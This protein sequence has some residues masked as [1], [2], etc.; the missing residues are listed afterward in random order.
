MG[1]GSC[2][3]C[4]FENVVFNYAHAAIKTHNVA[5][6]GSTLILRWVA[7][8]SCPDL[9]AELCMSISS[10]KSRFVKNLASRFRSRCS[11]SF[12]TFCYVG[13]LLP[14]TKLNPYS[15]RFFVFAVVIVNC[16]FGTRQRHHGYGFSEWRG[17][18]VQLCVFEP[19]I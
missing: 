7:C 19:V 17:H 18:E 16:M 12:M 10:T 3:G 15:R 14:P 4:P 11:V 8:V 2:F 13:V 9:F 6:E 1:L 5:A